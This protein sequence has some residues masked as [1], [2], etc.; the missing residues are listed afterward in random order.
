MA[1]VREPLVILTPDKRGP[2]IIIFC[3]SLASISVT[4]AVIRF[5]LAVFRRIRFDLDDVTY[6]L[7]NVRW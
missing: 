7:T 3:Y 4:T 2:I 1:G 5:G 6:I